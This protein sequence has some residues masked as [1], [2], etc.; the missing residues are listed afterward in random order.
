MCEVVIIGI[1]AN[2]A[3]VKNRV[4]SNQYAFYLL[5]AIYRQ[6]R[7]TAGHRVTVYL[8]NPPLDD[9]PPQESW[10]Q[11]RVFGPSKLWTQLALPWRLWQ[12][13]HLLDVFFTPGHYAPRWCPVP[14]V[15]SILDL[16]FLKYPQ[17]FRA[18]DLAQLK[19]WTA[20]SV[21]KAAHLIAISKATKKDIQKHYAVS[22]DQ[23]T[24]VYPGLI[25]L[26]GKPVSLSRFNIQKPYLLYVGTLQPRKNLV[27]LIQAFAQL[28]EFPGQLVIVGKKGWLYQPIFKAAYESGVGERLVFTGYVSDA[29]LKTLIVNSRLLINPSLYEG[30][31][32]PVLQAMSLGTPVLVSHCSS[33]PEIVGQAGFYIKDPHSVLS[34]KKGIIKALQASPSQQKKMAA[35]AK[36]RA[37]HFTWQ[38]A[39]LKTLKVLQK[40][41]NR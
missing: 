20:Y 9:L 21:K 18:Q 36:K 22:R 7:R 27:R 8:K 24:V 37:A 4:G 25:P 23:I 17:S 33:L 41:V 35:Q 34:I 19:S 31:G 32:L 6:L 10:W 40:V 39:A 2:E 29:E 11:Y 15:V 38:K 16:A 3:N 12:E 1:N 13:R 30:F 5:W 28:K 14:S 26:K